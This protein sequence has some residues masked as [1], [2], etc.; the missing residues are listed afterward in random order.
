MD[1][2]LCIIETTGADKIKRSVDI[3][4]IDGNMI[5]STGAHGQCIFF[6]QFYGQIT[7]TDK[8]HDPAGIGILCRMDYIESKLGVKNQTFRHICHGDP[9]ML[10]SECIICH[11][12]NQPY[13][14]C[15]AFL[16]PK[17]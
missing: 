6:V 14:L 7:K 12:H 8:I 3:T 5:D 4:D 15:N 16:T 1:L 11:S 13:L 9:N 2:I 10:K 17:R